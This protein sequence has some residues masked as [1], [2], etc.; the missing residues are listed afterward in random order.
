MQPESVALPGSD[1]YYVEVDT[2][3]CGSVTQAVTYSLRVTA[4]D[5]TD[6]AVTARSPGA[7][8]S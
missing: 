6:R 8:A 1:R 2:Y 5:F 7:P 4:G 3:S